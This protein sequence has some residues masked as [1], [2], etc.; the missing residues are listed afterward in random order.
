MIC[1]LTAKIDNLLALRI[2]QE[3]STVV[4]P[5]D[6]L[7]QMEVQTSSQVIFFNSTAGEFDSSRI[8]VGLLLLFTNNVFPD[9]NFLRCC[10]FGDT[11]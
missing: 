8:D 7:T 2:A 9:D 1:F 5:N 4:F 3:K 6:E 10:K 11:S